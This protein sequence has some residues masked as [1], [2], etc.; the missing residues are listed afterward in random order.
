MQDSVLYILESENVEDT[1]VDLRDVL[2]GARLTLKLPAQHALALI[3]KAGKVGNRQIW[4][5]N[6]KGIERLWLRLSPPS[7]AEIG[8]ADAFILPVTFLRF[9]T[10]TNKKAPQCQPS[11]VRME[12][13]GG[14]VF[15]S[16]TKK[17]T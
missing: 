5:L 17:S 7:R 6:F 3:V 11:P 4:L 13:H 2:T 1:P 10:Q 8:E 16:N 9:A 12:R 14:K 15:A